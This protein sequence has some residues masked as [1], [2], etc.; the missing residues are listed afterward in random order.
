MRNAMLTHMTLNVIAPASAIPNEAQAAFVRRSV[1]LYKDFIR[2]F[3][4]TARV[5]HHTPEAGKA[6]KN[7]FCALE[8]AAADCS[9]AALAAF[10]LP[11]ASKDRFTVYP[12]GLSAG[13]LY[14]VTLDN[15]G[16]SFERDGFS[17]MNGGL[18]VSLPAPMASELVLFE[19]VDAV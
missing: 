4:P 11:G 14:R 7:G 16:A 5:Y 10:T 19:A 9:R 8:L 17:L 6:R 15:S 1:A 3:L 12:R 13:R 18:T 2:P